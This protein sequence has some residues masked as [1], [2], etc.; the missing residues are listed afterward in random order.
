MTQTKLEPQVKTCADCSYFQSHDNGTNNGWCNLFDHFAKLTHQ[1]TQDCVNTIRDEEVSTQNE[2]E[3]Q[4]QEQELPAGYEIDSKKD[5]DF[6]ELF[7]LWKGWQ[8][9]GSFYKTLDG[10]W[11]VQPAKAEINGRFN[12]ETQAILVLIAIFENPELQAA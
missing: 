7:R 3:Q 6:G 1:Q 10:K 9:A 2:L 12:T 5:A 8:F 4:S 11:V